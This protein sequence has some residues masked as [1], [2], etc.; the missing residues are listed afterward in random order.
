MG[1]GGSRRKQGEKHMQVIRGMRGRRGEQEEGW[2][3]AYASE[4]GEKG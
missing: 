2:R 1:G 4:E 3:E